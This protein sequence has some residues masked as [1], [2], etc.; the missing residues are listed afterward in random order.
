[1]SIA[2]WMFAGAIVGWL[3]HAVVGL[4][5]ERG[6]LISIVIGAFGGVVGGHVLAPVLV[7]P[8][9]AQTGVS[10]PTM[11]IALAFAATLLCVGN[12]VHKRW[13]I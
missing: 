10:A 11:F 6:L 5:A 7:T 9:A 1:M 3:A 2:L 4:N 12:L 13:G 8:A